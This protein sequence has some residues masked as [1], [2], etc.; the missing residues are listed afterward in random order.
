MPG[1]LLL[2]LFTLSSAQQQALRNGQSQGGRQLE[3]WNSLLHNPADDDNDEPELLH[4]SLNLTM[5]FDS[6]ENKIDD[7]FEDVEQGSTG[8]LFVCLLIVAPVSLL[9]YWCYFRGK[10]PDSIF[11]GGGSF[12][13]Q[14]FS[15]VM[16]NKTADPRRKA[17]P[18]GPPMP[19]RIKTPKRANM[20]GPPLSA[21]VGPP[22]GGIW[23]PTPMKANGTPAPKQQENLAA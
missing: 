3:D 16:P 21:A 11:R 7:R 13:S 20:P 9:M 6:N 5:S 1:V 12:S 19:Q 4:N 2:L 10:S 14:N 18:P 22:S 15:S 8:V 17:Y 23:L